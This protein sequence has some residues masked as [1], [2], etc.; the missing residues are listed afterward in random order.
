MHIIKASWF[1][2]PGYPH[3]IGIVVARTDEGAMQAFIGACAG[4]G[5][6]EDAMRVA[7]SGAHFPVAAAHTLPDMLPAIEVQ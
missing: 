5:E 4:R 1:A 2:M 3:T 6:L 7:A